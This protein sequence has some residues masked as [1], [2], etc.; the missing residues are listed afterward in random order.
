[1]K[2]FFYSLCAALTL[3]LFA[4]CANTPS[5]VAT[6]YLDN[7]KKGDYA[8]MVDQM[9]FKKNMT[10]KDKG[11]II[12]ILEEKG[13]ETIEKNE[14]IAGFVI[15]SEEIAEDGFTAKVN[16]TL[17]YGNGKTKDEE[18]KLVKVNDKWMLDS[19]K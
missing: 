13:K 9:H 19:G 12:S 10:D 18:I 6:D 7:F 5:S 8:A 14:G 17:T 16:Y 2:K 4:S 15:V 1:M 3:I 11:E